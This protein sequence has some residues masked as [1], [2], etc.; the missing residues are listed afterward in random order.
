MR[1]RQSFGD[2]LA[3]FPP[4]HR[5]EA[6]ED[7]NP[8]DSCRP[9]IEKP[10]PLLPYKGRNERQCALP[11]FKY[12]EISLFI[13]LILISAGAARAFT[14]SG[15]FPRPGGPASDSPTGTSGVG[16]Y[17][18]QSTET[19]LS[20]LGSGRILDGHRAAGR[21]LQ[22]AFSAAEL[23][24]D[25]S[26]ADGGEGA[27]TY[28]ELSPQGSKDAQQ[29]KAL[30]GPPS[31]TRESRKRTRGVSSNSHT[32]TKMPS[33]LPRRSLL[34]RSSMQTEM[35][36]AMDMMRPRAQ[37][38]GFIRKLIGWLTGA[39]A[40]ADANEVSALAKKMHDWNQQNQR[41]PEGK[42]KLILAMR[43]AE[44]EFNVWRR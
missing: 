33:F 7:S 16:F 32:P 44:S 28:M 15:T 2:F 5:M 29:P 25:F 4:W 1:V 8:P 39:P 20:P 30:L 13:C 43:H 35:V 19:I 38:Y 31:F 23:D 42:T 11:S 26:L 17:K 12:S 22:G 37:S 36:E 27:D 21:A 18:T 14:R 6:S 3:V 34:T 9:Q 40:V 24:G 10:C 41:R